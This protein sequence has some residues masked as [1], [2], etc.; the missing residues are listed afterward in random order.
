MACRRVRGSALS[1]RR[2]CSVGIVHSVRRSYF[3]TDALHDSAAALV[4]SNASVHTRAA[5][6]DVGLWRRA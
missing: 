4:C 1:A 2:C 3:W 5:S 6:S